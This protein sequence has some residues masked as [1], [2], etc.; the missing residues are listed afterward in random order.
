MYI[1]DEAD[2]AVS[3]TPQS[4]YPYNNLPHPQ[5]PQ[6]IAPPRILRQT[7]NHI[8]PQAIKYHLHPT[9]PRTDQPCIVAH[10]VTPGPLLESP[11]HLLAPLPPPFVPL[12][13]LAP[14]HNQPTPPRVPLAATLSRGSPHCRARRASAHHA[15]DHRHSGRSKHP[16]CRCGVLC[17]RRQIRTVFASCAARM[18]DDAGQGCVE[19][20]GV[21]GGV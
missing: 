17:A 12:R 16:V 13:A 15:S 7:V 20:H 5:T 3:I 1:V 9:I 4:V 14:S 19:G 21:G 6:G 11:P 18:D 10:N 8:N 2:V